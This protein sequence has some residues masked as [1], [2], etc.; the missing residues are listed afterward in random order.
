MKMQK[1]VGFF[2]TFALVLTYIPSAGAQTYIPET[3]IEY[4]DSGPAFK[5]EGVIRD[6]PTDTDDTYSITRSKGDTLY[7]RTVEADGHVVKQIVYDNGSSYVYDQNVQELVPAWSHASEYTWSKQVSVSR[8][9]QGSLSGDVA[10]SIAA[11][12]GVSKSITKSFSVSVTIP[13]DS[14]R[15]SKLVLSADFFQ[16]NLRS[17]IYIDSKLNTDKTSTVLYPE[18]LYLKVVYK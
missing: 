5:L 14:S 7:S 12:L 10:D 1:L 2:L 6:I 11:S 18:D 3:P 15:Y 4:T 13:A 17:K 9:I 16:Q 8:Q